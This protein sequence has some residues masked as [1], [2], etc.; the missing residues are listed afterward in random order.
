MTAGVQ[1]TVAQRTAHS[2]A[3]CTIRTFW[4]STT[5]QTTRVLKTAL[6]TT[7]ISQPLQPNN[8]HVTAGPSYP[9]QFG[10]PHASGTHS[11][12]LTER[13]WMTDD[14]NTVWGKGRSLSV[15]TS[16]QTAAGWGFELG[17]YHNLVGLQ[18]RTVDMLTCRMSVDTLTRRLCHHSPISNI[19]RYSFSLAA[20]CLCVL[21]PCAM[22]CQIK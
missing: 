22:Y 6:W 1:T 12:E 9:Q 11:A 7:Q 14:L 13:L 19:L 17:T 20:T 16:R 15:A 21:A 4:C 10:Q 8:L 3:S 18:S 5:S 2:T